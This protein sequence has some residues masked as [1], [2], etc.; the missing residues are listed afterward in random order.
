MKDVRDTGFSR[1]RR[2]NVGSRPPPSRPCTEQITKKREKPRAPLRVETIA[3]GGEPGENSRV[4]S[5]S[6]E[7][8]I[9]F[10]HCGGRQRG[11][12]PP[13]VVITLFY[14]FIVL[15]CFLSHR[16]IITVVMSH[17]TTPFFTDQ[18]PSPALILGDHALCSSW[19]TTPSSH[20]P[21][22]RSISA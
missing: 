2:G 1:K 13:L 9:K 16:S 7:T 20:A 14:S 11:P 8:H 4:R 21:W 22:R 5:R 3:E 19:P 6:T 15:L 17:K 10:N 12:L 18:P